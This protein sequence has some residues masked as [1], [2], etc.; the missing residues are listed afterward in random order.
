MRGKIVKGGQRKKTSFLVTL[1]IGNNLGTKKLVETLIYTW[2]VR[3][4]KGLYVILWMYFPKL[5]MTGE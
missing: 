2:T 4:E 5:I 1:T 3:E